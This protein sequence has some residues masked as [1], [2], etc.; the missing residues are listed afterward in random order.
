MFIYECTISLHENTF[1]SSREINNFYQTEALLGNYA[2]TY[3]FGFASSPYN[4]TAILYRQHFSELNNRGIYVTPAKAV[5]KTSFAISQFNATSESYWSKVEQNAISTDIN[6]KTGKS[7]GARAA[8]IPQIGRIK[9]LGI[10]SK[11]V[12]YIL[13]KSELQIP[14]YIRLGKFMSK[15]KVQTSKLEN[16]VSDKA[17]EFTSNALLNPVDLAQDTELG[18][19]DLFSVHPVPLIDNARIRAKSYHLSN[20][21]EIPYGMRYGVEALTT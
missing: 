11:F 3:A 1:F 10:N 9:M 12:C 8:N 15:A 21:V 5:G 13:S 18:I 14:Q 19:Y 16:K 6:V 4:N 17:V 2:L 7:K 20:G